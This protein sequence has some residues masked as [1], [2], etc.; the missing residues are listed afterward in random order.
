MD[1]R[2]DRF[3]LFDSLRAIA[4]LMV[5][6]S[7]IGSFGGV[8]HEGDPLRPYV[9]Q[10]AV[11]VPIFLLISGFLLYR[12]FA[13]ARLRGRNR[14]SI[15]AYGW[16]RVLRIVP[17][18]WVAVTVITIWLGSNY[19]FHGGEQPIEVFSPT[20]VL[21]YYGF[22][23]LY[24]AS[25]RGGGIPQAWTIDTEV[26][27]YI[28]LP[29]YAL[30]VFWLLRRYGM[31]WRG[32]VA[33][34]GGIIVLSQL[35]KLVVVEAD[36]M[37]TVP[38]TP[39]PLFSGAAGLC[40][41]L[42]ARDGARRDERRRRADERRA[43]GRRRDRAPAVAAV[44][45]SRDRV[46]GRRDADR[47]GG[48]AGRADVDRAVLRSPRALR[49]GRASGCCCRPSSATTRAAGS[50]SCSATAR[51]STSAWS[52]TACTSGTSPGSSSSCTGTSASTR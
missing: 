2:A 27:F 35:Y 17:A 24:S 26:A 50:A 25:T 11:A 52:A 5:I 29:L 40:R 28:A 30:L 1:T 4:A 46:L 37:E 39:L 44:A 16:R 41:P 3:P 20:G 42:R 32:E 12:P 6:C 47:D 15:P 38:V 8:L 19:L 45:G 43:A 18:Y 49:R 48:V 22:G 9:G 21:A 23:Q 33:L 34:L 10:F 7:H 14:P 31:S 13:A 36:G 51:C